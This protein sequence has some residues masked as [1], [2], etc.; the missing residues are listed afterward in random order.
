MLAPHM[1]GILFIT[2]IEPAATGNG[3]AMRARG[4][5][6]ALER[7]GTVTTVC[8]PVSQPGRAVNDVRGSRLSDRDHAAAWLSTPKGRALLSG[9]ASLPLRAREA[10]AAITR[11]LLKG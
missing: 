6:A 7:Q 10:S 1:P 3:L 2:P 9:A 11:P 8:I 4:I 5:Q